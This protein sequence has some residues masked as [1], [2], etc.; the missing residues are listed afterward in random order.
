MR[1]KAWLITEDAEQLMHLDGDF[2]HPTNA[3]EFGALS[4]DPHAIWWLQFKWDQEKAQG[5]PFHGIDTE[6]FSK[7]GYVTVQSKT[8][9]DGPWKHRCDRGVNTET[10]QRTK[11]QIGCLKMGGGLLKIRGS[12]AHILPLKDIFGDDSSGKLPEAA[13][14]KPFRYRYKEHIT[15]YIVLD[16]DCR[17]ANDGLG[18]PSKYVGPDETG[19]KDLTDVKTADF[20]FD[21]KKKRK[22]TLNRRAQHGLDSYDHVPGGF[23]AGLGFV[24][25]PS[26]PR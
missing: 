22:K 17:Y 12:V 16:P 10:V 19:E 13:V 3:G 20:G 21:K 1:F 15:P 9:P 7:L 11:H 8:M 4:S 26:P 6:K 23:E 14:D 18:V 2:F 24:P 5:R 25:T